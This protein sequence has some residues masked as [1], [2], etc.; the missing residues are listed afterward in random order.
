MTLEA[1]NTHWPTDLL[2]PT[3][4]G[5]L[6][7]FFVSL[8]I[9]L[10]TSVSWPWGFHWNTGTAMNGWAMTN[11]CRRRGNGVILFDVGKTIIPHPWLGMVTKN[12][13]FISIKMDFMVSWGMVDVLATFIIWVWVKFAMEI[14]GTPD[15]PIPHLVGR[16][17]KE[18]GTVHVLQRWPGLDADLEKPGKSMGKCGEIW[19][20]YGKWWE[21]PL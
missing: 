5:R 18:L 20:K 4:G 2:W 1:I 7:C 3:N 21:N 8:S 12:R 13:L 11:K 9:C 19:E 6:A 14:H 16:D 15:P 17:L 10:K